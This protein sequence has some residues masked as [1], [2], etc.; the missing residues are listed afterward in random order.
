M[1]FTHLLCPCAQF[2]RNL[3]TMLQCLEFIFKGY[4]TGFV[5]RIV[6]ALFFTPNS[7]QMHQ[8]QVRAF[9]KHM[10]KKNNMKIMDT[11]LR[12]LFLNMIKLLLH[13]TCLYFR[14]TKMHIFDIIIMSFQDRSRLRRLNFQTWYK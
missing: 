13:R 3:H 1:H 6:F 8:N 5:G 11:R 4:K 2:L 9:K 12:D 10:S 7:C 14:I